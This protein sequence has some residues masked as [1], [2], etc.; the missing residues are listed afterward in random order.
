MRRLLIAAIAM[1][2]GFFGCGNDL[3]SG[4]SPTVLGSCRL[5]GGGC[6]V[7]PQALCSGVWVEGGHCGSV[8]PGYLPQSSA[9]AVLANLQRTY[10]ERRLAQ[11]RKLFSDDFIFVFNPLDPEDP[12]LPHPDQWGL[13]DELRSTE[14]MF[15]DERVTK[16]ELTSYTLDPCARADSILY[17]PNAWKARVDEVNL[18]VATLLPDGNRLT[19]VVQGATERFFFRTDPSQPAA[20]GKPTWTIFRWEDQPV[21]TGKS[22]RGSWGQIKAV[23]W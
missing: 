11:Y 22:E 12:D 20:D 16:V 14:N 9:A 6:A 8:E 17:G 3:L 4:A 1:A 21:G 23:Y 7:T 15:A 13:A 19:L 5:P 10:A 18:Q 2:T